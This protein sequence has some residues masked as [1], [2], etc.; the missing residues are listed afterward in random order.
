MTPAS[1]HTANFENW[2]GTPS[3]GILTIVGPLQTFVRLE[4]EIDMSMSEEFGQLLLSLPSTTAELV[5]DVTGLTFCDCTLANFVA[6]M[7]SYM[8]ITV[9][10]RNPW[11]IEFLQLVQLFDRVRIV[12]PAQH[13]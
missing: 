7:L 9:T 5:L 3:G 4:G 13:W 12:D 6:S 11:V 2:D 10:P 8:P 1:A